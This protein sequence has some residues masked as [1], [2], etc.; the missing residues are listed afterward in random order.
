VALHAQRQGL[1]P[2]QRRKAVCAAM[3][4]PKSR[5]PSRR[6]R[7]RKGATVLSSAKFMP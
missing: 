1:D 7:S 6:A 3:Q 4:A 2:L 5:S